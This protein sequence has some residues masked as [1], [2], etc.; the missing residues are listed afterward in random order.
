MTRITLV[1]AVP[2]A[3]QPVEDA[4]KTLWRET[5]RTN[6]LDNSL[7]A[8]REQAGR[9]TPELSARIFSLAQYAVSSGADAVLF[10]CSAFGEA[11][12]AAAAVLPATVLKPNEA[13]FDAALEIGG[14]IG[15]LATFAPAVASM[16]EEF[17]DLARRRGASA[18]LETVLVAGAREAL[19]CGQLDK[20]DGLIAETASNLTSCNA[21]MLAH[22][23]MAN[24][25]ARIRAKAGRPVLA[26]PDS[27]VLKLRSILTKSAATSVKE[28]RD[29]MT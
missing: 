14:R 29:R 7:A 3:M 23:S 13:M 6:L 21:I 16:E 18:R 4:F 10:T 20:H 8:D 9:L 2:A 24:A 11:I 25:A 17:N 1:H 15:M 28:T 12:E 22:F 19:L 27:A 5:N 26:A